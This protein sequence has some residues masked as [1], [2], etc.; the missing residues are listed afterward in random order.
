MAV[1]RAALNTVLASGAPNT[2]AA[3]QEALVADPNASKRRTLYLDKSER[4][5]LL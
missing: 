2:E 1:L 3:W 4:L 5:K